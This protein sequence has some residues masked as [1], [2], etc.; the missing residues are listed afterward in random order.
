V[1]KV[2]AKKVVCTF[3]AHPVQYKINSYSAL[4]AIDEQLQD[5]HSAGGKF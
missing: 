4:G 5:S 2:I 3:L 1:G